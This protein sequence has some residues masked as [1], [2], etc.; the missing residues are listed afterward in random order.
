M[1]AGADWSGVRERVFAVA[2]AEQKARR[3]PPSPHP[4]LASVLTSDEIAEVEDQHGTTLPDEYRS[5]LAE[6]GAGGVGPEILLTTLRKIGG[7]WGWFS[8]DDVRSPF[9]L[10]A[11]GPFIETEDW[12]D[13]QVATLRDAG[14]EPTVRDEEMDYLEDYRWAFRNL[15]DELWHGQRHQGAIYISDNGCGM[16]GWLI[17]VG[18]NRGQVRDRDC[19][20]NPPFEPYLDAHGNRHTFHTWYLEWLEQQEEKFAEHLAR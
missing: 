18:P 4:A 16:T 10:D 1:N 12:P 2:L 6:V 14:H 17:V 3:W 19:G 13:V 5:F 15:A 7:R 8:E 20:S 11:S 9:A